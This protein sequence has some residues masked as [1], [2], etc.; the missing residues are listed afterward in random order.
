MSPSPSDAA[1]ARPRFDLFVVLAEMRTGSNF[2]EANLNAIPG[3]RCHGEAFNPH[4]LGYP[5]QEAM[6]GVTR[7]QR[8]ADP[9]FLIATLR[10]QGGL[11][12]FRLFGDHDPRAVE[13]VLA[14]PACAKI[15]LTRNPAESYVSRKI[16]ALTGQWKL[17]N[18]AHARSGQVRFEAGE[19]AAHLER[20]QAF[21]L[22]ILRALQVSGQTAFWV[23]YEDIQDLE[24]MQGL[25]RFLGAAPPEG[26]D[27]KLKKQNPEPLAEKVVNFAEMEA[28]LGP[29]DRFDLSRTPNFEPRRGAMVPRMVAAFGADLLHLPIPGGPEEAVRGWLASLDAEGRL[30]EGFNARTL[31]QW[32][33]ARPGHRS[34]A[35]L[36]HPLARAHA[37]FCE[38]ILPAGPD[39]FGELR[40]TLRRSFALPVPEGGLAEGAPWSEGEHRAAFARFL[41]FVKANLGGQTALRTDAAWA[42]QAS[43]VQGFSNLNP[44]DLILREEELGE[45]LPRLAARL[46]APARPYAPPPDPLAARLGAI[47]DDALEALA[48][49]AYAR[50]MVLFGFGRWRA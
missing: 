34:F 50:D 28:A 49:E 19:F 1:P 29:L 24:V 9:G 2:L 27:R 44:P 47:H 12:G 35:V 41:E 38:R 23:D 40:E 8:D 33:L 11:N 46:G 6:L 16:A 7:A 5:G 3:L 14:D 10:A 13:A 25:A 22:R 43:V 15:V 17:T 36:R 45:D 42:S 30:V 4:F 37:V 26:L 39:A 20:L 32:K 18:A 21:Q 48:R 31:R